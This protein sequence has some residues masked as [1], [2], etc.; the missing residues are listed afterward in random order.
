MFT[1]SE[2]SVEHM[3]DPF[4]ILSGERFEFVLDL[5]VE[6]DDELYEEEGVSLRVIYLVDGEQ[7]RIVKYEFLNRTTNQYIDIELEEDEFKWV[8][9]Y[10][11]E[12]L[13]QPGEVQ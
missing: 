12:C 9:A 8:D 3:K 5:E 11:K 13:E 2:Y 1:V 6:E 10:C 4:G 7:S